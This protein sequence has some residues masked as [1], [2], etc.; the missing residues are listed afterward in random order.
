MQC[1]RS[2][3]GPL[4][5]LGMFSWGHMC[6]ALGLAVRSVPQASTWSLLLSSLGFLTAW[7]FQGF[8]PRCASAY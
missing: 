2:Q 3:S 8:K 4:E 6:G 1:L 5:H 7:Q